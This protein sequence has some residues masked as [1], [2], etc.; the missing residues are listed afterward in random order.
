VSN[1]DKEDTWTTDEI[2]RA[3]HETRTMTQFEIDLRQAVDERDFAFIAAAIIN[4]TEMDTQMGPPYPLTSDD[5]KILSLVVFMLLNGDIKPP[6]HRSHNKHT[7]LQNK[8]ILECFQELRSQGEKPEAAIKAA[9]EETGISER[10]LWNFWTEAVVLDEAKQELDACEPGERVKVFRRCYN[11]LAAL[12]H[13]A[14]LRRPKL[15][16]SR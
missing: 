11:R 7:R 14:H 2:V 10:W 1:S 12:P 9:H 16:R 4:D 13:M 8:A 5:R 15:K 3:L 6:A